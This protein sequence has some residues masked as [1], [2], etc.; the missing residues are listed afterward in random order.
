VSG[1]RSL[2]DSD[3]LSYRESEIQDS[4]ERNSCLTK[5]LT[6]QSRPD[7]A[8]RNG[9]LVRLGEVFNKKLFDESLK[10]ISQTGQFEVIDADKDVDYSWDQ[11]SP[12]VDL[13]IRLK[14]K[15]PADEE[16][17]APRLTP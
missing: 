6:L 4:Q 13:T 14:K 2:L 17:K 11:K 8:L 7:N 10:R 1:T 16:L 15:A 9:M 5:T 3:Q 12:R